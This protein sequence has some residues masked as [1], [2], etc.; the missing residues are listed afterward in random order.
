LAD[1]FSALRETDPAK[2]QSLADGLGRLVREDKL[3]RLGI[4]G[5]KLFPDHRIVAQSLV[6]QLNF[7]A[8]GQR[9]SRDLA[10]AASASDCRKLLGDYF[11]SYLAWDIAHG[12]HRLWGWDQWQMGPPSDVAGRLAR[13]V[14]DRS[15]IDRCFREVGRT[16]SAKY[17]KT[18]VE[19]GCI[20]PLRSAVLAAIP[21]VAT[22]A[23]KAKATASVTP[24]PTE[25]PASNANDGRLDTLYWPGALTENN[26][27][28]LQLAW[29]KPQTFDKVI[30]RFLPHPSM[31]GRTIHLQKEVAPGKWEDFAT[32]TIPADAAATHAVATFRLPNRVTLDKVRVVNLLDVFEVE[33][34]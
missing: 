24:K 29:D 13:R 3:G 23:Q 2:I 31:H 16:L 9:L 17:D 10:P 5:R 20:A 7:R 1:C 8:A 28:W 12:W 22:L 4:F 34:Y 25:Y 19:A 14:G 18:A 26:T 6:L 11:D 27:E 21:T 30:V 15:A 33:V 32:T